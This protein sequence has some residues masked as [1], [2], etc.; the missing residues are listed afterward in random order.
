MKT[1]LV[2]PSADRYIAGVCAAVANALGLS[3]FNVRVA[4]VIGSVFSFGLVAGIYIVL[5]I[6]LPSQT[7]RVGSR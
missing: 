5:W 4:T 7:T 3:P 1:P 2:R 6:A